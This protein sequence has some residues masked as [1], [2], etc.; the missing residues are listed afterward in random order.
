MFWAYVF[1]LIA[2]ILLMSAAI[3]RKSFG[4]TVMYIAYLAIDGIGFLKTLS[5][6]G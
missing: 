3:S 6:L 2:T 4:F 1:F 5:W